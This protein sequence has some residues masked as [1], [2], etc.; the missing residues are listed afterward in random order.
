MALAL[1]EGRERRSQGRILIDGSREIDRALRAGVTML[2]AWADNERMAFDRDTQN[3]VERLAVAG[4]SVVEAGSQLLGRLAEERERAVEERRMLDAI[5]SERLESAAE[6]HRRFARLLVDGLEQRVD[7]GEVA[8][9]REREQ[10]LL[11]GEVSV[12]QGLV[13]AHAA[14]DAVDTRVLGPALVEQ[15][16]G[17]VEDLA[18][19]GATDR[20]AGRL[21]RRHP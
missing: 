11:G 4:A 8:R 16:S 18:L 5:V 1:R 14:R 2:E 13:D 3:L 19:A 9:G 6:P 17:C 21:P 20:R 15:G 7:F 10:L 12:D